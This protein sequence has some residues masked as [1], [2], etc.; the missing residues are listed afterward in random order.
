MA[1]GAGVVL[2]REPRLG[3]MV[4]PVIALLI[5]LEIGTGTDVSVNAAV[6]VVPPLVVAWLVSRIL[7]RNLRFV[8]SRLNPP[9]L[10]L[11]LIIAFSLLRGN[12]AWDIL[13]PKP[14]NALLVQL[15][16]I[17]IYYFS[18][19]AFWLTANLI[20]DQRKLRQLTYVTL[21]TGAIGTLIVFIS[22]TTGIVSVPFQAAI[23]HNM[24]T[25]WTVGLCLTMLFYDNSLSSLQQ[26]LLLLYVALTIGT[27]LLVWTRSADWIGG[28]FPPLLAGGVIVWIRFP[29]LRVPTLLILLLVLAV[30]APSSLAD[31]PGL[32]AKWQTSGNSRLT[33]WRSVLELARQSPIFGLGIAAYRYYHYVKPLVYINAVW[34][35][36]RVSAHNMYVDMFAQLG[37]VGV[38]AY[39][40]FQFEAIRM[41]TKIYRHGTGF[42]RGYALAALAALIG[43]FAADMLAATSLPF[44][45]NLGFRGFRASLVSWMLLGGL[46]VLENHVMQQDT[47]QAIP[48]AKALS[49]GTPVTSSSTLPLTGTDTTDHRLA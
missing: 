49:R 12:A 16:Q 45:Y 17:A 39:G 3:L 33:I 15:S 8:K 6:L 7:S 42:A 21:I 20:T 43:S 19:L 36:P 31:I 41:A 38:L 32:E 47:D 34:V 22:Q 9:L 26:G 29:R 48:S 23:M 44:I 18:F 14:D 5:P 4:L 40:W 25:L 11:S 37:L 30:K 28:W 1:A 10:V 13:V 24:F 46:V 2:L 27:I 35:T